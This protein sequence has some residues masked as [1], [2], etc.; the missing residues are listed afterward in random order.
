MDRVCAVEAA[1]APRACDPA[2]C[3]NGRLSRI[4]RPVLGFGFDLFAETHG[5]IEVYP[6]GYDGH[7][8]DIKQQ[9]SLAA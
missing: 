3:I 2:A 7:S 1:G 4:A 9:V 8:N 5:F 6:Q